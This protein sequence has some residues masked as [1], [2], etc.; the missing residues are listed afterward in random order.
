MRHYFAFPR[1][2]RVPVA[3]RSARVPVAL[4]SARVQFATVL[5]AFLALAAALDAQM[6]HRLKGSIR[7]AAGAPLVGAAIRADNVFGFRGEEFAGTKE[8]KTTSIDKGE[9]N[10]TG[11]EAGLWMFSTTAPDS[12][13]AVIVIPVKFSHRQQVSAVGNSLTWQL[14][15]WAYPASDHPMLKVTLELLA[16]GKHEEAVQ[17][18]TVALGPDIPIETRVAAGELSLLL[19]Q[20]AMASA[21]FNL[22]LQQNPKHPR[23]TLGLAGATLMARDWERAGKLVW[24]ARDL[25]PKEQRQALAAAI[26]D[27]RAIARVQ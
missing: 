2:A 9:W 3:L 19:K 16:A 20:Y 11:I 27:L 8:H 4:R 24:D 10:I 26:D 7:T 14:P 15:I 13:P 5:L 12:V 1:S 22:A 25:V 23:A 6:A 18:V 17:A 21:I